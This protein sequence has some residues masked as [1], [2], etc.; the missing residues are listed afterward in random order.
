MAEASGT[1]ALINLEGDLEVVAPDGAGRRRLTSGDRFFQFPAWSP[2]ASRIATIGRN[3]L[4]S[5]VFVFDF[6]AFGP[7]DPGPEQT[8][9]ESARNFPIY[10]YWSPD[11]QYV[12]FIAMRGGEQSMGL[13]LA[14]ADKSTM[15]T[16]AQPQLI[17]TGQPCF[18][19]W[20]ADGQRI[21]AHVGG[22]DERG[23]RLTM[24]NPFERG[25]EAR[26]SIAKPGLF[27]APGI[28]SSGRYR[29]FGQ[30]TRKKDAELLVE[31]IDGD[32]R[33]TIE[34]K[35]V[36]AMNWSPTRDQLAFISP[37]G[38]VRTY[39]GPLKLVD[40][41]SGDVEVI[42]D[43]VV[44]AFFWSPDGDR[45]A[46]FTVAQIADA[47]AGVFPDPSTLARD[48]GAQLRVPSPGDAPQDAPD[49]LDDQDGDTDGDG[50]VETGELWLNLWVVDVATRE[51][52]L[53]ATF[54]P[55]D[56]FVNQFLPFFDQYAKSHR[57]W[58]PDSRALVLPM[59]K[60]DATGRR[61][62]TVCVAP[63][64]PEDGG[65]RRLGEGLMAFWSPR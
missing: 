1:I 18:W 27:Q 60:I 24:I 9:Y 17:A 16:G 57:L 58:S 36:A 59:M 3:R 13:H 43:D 62:A 51:S 47:V 22:W 40:V 39:Y 45:I 52:S 64:F 21:I 37:P 34:H 12:S 28:A 6:D 61:A 20:T 55:V 15:K 33:I 44:L 4:K 2:D 56:L 25:A 30:W 46:Y 38:P 10:L 23:S 29:A 63:V 26:S 31:E 8:A 11:S 48:G 42:G 53:V 49:D 65:V 5:G 54:E 35:G 41:A 19:E 32:A 50:I 14:S 7:S